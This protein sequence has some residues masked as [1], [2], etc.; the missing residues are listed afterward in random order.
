VI[1]R[2]ASVIDVP[3]IRDIAYKTWPVAY[4]PILSPAQLHYMLELMYSEEALHDQL[5]VRGHRFTLAM[6]ESVAQGFA[7]FETAYNGLR[8]TRLHK[9]YVLPSAQGT[10]AGKHLIAHVIERAKEHGDAAVELNVNRFNPAR[11]F[12]ERHGFRI[13]RD[14]VIDIGHGFVMD[15]HVMRLDLARRL[16]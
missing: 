4:G 6:L 2:E 7:G 9:L 8:V 3:V 11:G 16:V 1:L 15:D 13:I 14:E 12:Y 5:V 10:G